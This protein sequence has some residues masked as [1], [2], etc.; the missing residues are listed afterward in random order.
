MFTI[1][2]VM[3]FMKQSKTRKLTLKSVQYGLEIIFK[4]FINY[5]HWTENVQSDL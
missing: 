1:H 3:S 4:L 5:P 2:F